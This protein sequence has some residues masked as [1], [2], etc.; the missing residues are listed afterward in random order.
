MNLQEQIIREVKKIGNGAHIFTPKEWIGEKVIIVR[1][2]KKS[3]KERILK[4]LEPHLGSIKGVYLYGSYSRNEETKDSDI[5]LLVITNNRINI[6]EK[7]FEVISLEE[8]KLEDAIKISPLLIYS[9]I[10]EATPIINTEL[11]KLI[12]E[13]YKI[14]KENF[15]QYIKETK[16]IININKE[17]LDPYS[18]ILRLRGIFII[19]GLLNNHDYSNKKFKEWILKNCRN[20]DIENLLEAYN[21]I[22]R[23][24]KII[25]VKQKD[26]EKILQFLEKETIKLERKLK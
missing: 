2:K 10:S 9:A 13:K 26:L 7:G 14:K 19:K 16:S 18:I 15:K 21:K 12:K 1:T 11:L 3:L 4:I 24:N 17:L 20:V 22:K 5:D 8:G 6:K 25:K 23:E